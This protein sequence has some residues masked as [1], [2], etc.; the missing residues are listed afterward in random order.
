M[1][2]NINFAKS[3][4]H[5]S[6]FLKRLPS[7]S[8]LNALQII[9]ETLFPLLQSAVQILLHAPDEA[10]QVRDLGFSV[11]QGTNTLV[12]VQQT[13]AAVLPP[14]YGVCVEGSKSRSRCLAECQA[15]QTAE[16]CGCTDVYMPPVNGGGHS[17]AFVHLSVYLRPGDGSVCVSVLPFIRPSVNRS[18]AK[19][20]SSSCVNLLVWSPFV[21]RFERSIVSFVQP[22]VI[23]SIDRHSG[24]HPKSFLCVFQTHYNVEDVNCSSLFK[25]SAS[26]Q[27]VFI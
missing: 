22:S 16:N 19:S 13:V 14:P 5:S 25:F 2:K 20:V 18:S 23:N 3:Y 24:R 12:A 8:S 15:M 4:L 26:L 1:L 21:R 11:A 6:L 9:N 17:V 27:S 10:P 7:M